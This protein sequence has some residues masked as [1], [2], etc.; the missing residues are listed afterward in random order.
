MSVFGGQLLVYGT[1]IGSEVA[2]AHAGAQELLV[3]C[4]EIVTDIFVCKTFVSHDV[5]VG[6][7]LN[8]FVYFVPQ[9]KSCL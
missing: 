3:L 7:K 6:G 9:Q 2:T 5:M 1:S 8:I 4:S